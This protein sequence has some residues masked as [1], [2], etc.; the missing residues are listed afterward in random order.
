[1]MVKIVNYGMQYGIVLFFRQDLPKMDGD[2]IFVFVKKDKFFVLILHIFTIFVMYINLVFRF[3]V[4]VN[5]P[6]SF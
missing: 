4:D 1:M 2:Y 5:R 6:L 3:G